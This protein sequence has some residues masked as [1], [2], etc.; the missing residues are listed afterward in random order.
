[1]Y[2][3][4]SPGI[5]LQ[6]LWDDIPALGSRAAERLPY[7]TQK[8]LTLLERII[9]TSSKEGQVV[10]DPFCGCGTAVHAAHRLKRQWIGLDITHLAI[11]LIRNRLETAFPGIEYDVKGLPADIAGARELAETDP[12]GFQWWGLF[13]IGARPIG[14]GVRR[15]GKK[16]KDRGVD[17][18][19]RFRDDPKATTSHRITVSV[20]AGKNLSPSMVRD[21]RGTME[22]DEAPI[23]VLL[24]MHEPTAEMRTE[25][26]KA[27]KWQSSSFYNKKYD[28][29]QLITV[30]QAFAGKRPEYP[31]YDVTLQAAPTD[32]PHKSSFTLPGLEAETAP[33][34]SGRSRGRKARGATLAPRARRRRVTRPQ[35]SRPRRRR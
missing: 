32:D 13:F 24:T 28:R 12:Y 35:S 25:A 34:K 27:G 18:L 4:E 9:G 1:M 17:G 8:P 30:E 15:E 6:N 14:N 10:L 11:G 16:G 20:K 5:K 21:L 31:G 29:I 33:H 19:I 26:A 22:R 7:P 3:D 23:G 2:L